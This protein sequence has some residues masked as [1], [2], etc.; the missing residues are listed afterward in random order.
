[1][2]LYF[3]EVGA[4]TPLLILHGLFGSGD[5]WMTIARRLAEE[6]NY[7]IYLPDLRNHG[8]SPHSE[9]WTYEAMSEDVRAFI[10][11]H[12]L[13]RPIVLG[14][15]MGGKVTMW[16]ACRYPELLRAIV[17]ADIAPRAYPVH[18]DTIIE[19]LLAIPV[20]TIKSRREAD[21]ILSRYVPETGVRQFLLKNLYRT[22]E[23]GYA[24]RMNLKVIANQLSNVVEGLPGNYRADLPA[25]FIRGLNSDYVRDEDIPVIKQHFP[26]ARIADIAGAGHWLHA[27]QPE[28]FLQHLKSFLQELDA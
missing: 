26:R 9:E 21:Q 5:N 15:S 3:Q 28:Q 23:G 24:W 11:E 16:L 17:V 19:G 27:E 12:A 22:E 2:K 14:H 25:L 20:E 18:H 8:R 7:H 6:G 4:G 1:M 10:E 13:Q